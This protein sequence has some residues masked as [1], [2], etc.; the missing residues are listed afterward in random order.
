MINWRALDNVPL[1]LYILAA[2]TLLLCLAFAGAKLYQQKKN[3]LHD[4]NQSG[5]KAAHSTETAVTEKLHAARSAKLSSVLIL[6]DLSAAFDTVNHKTLLSTLRSLG[7]CGTAWEWFA[8]YL[9]GRSYQGCILPPLLFSLYTNDCTSTHP[10]VKLLKFADDT[11][12]IDLIQDGDESAYRQEVEQLAAWC[13]LN[14]LELNTLKTVEMI[15][16]FRMNTPALPPLTIMNSTVPTVE[17]FRF[18]GTT[19]SQDLKWDTDIDSIIKKIVLPSAAEE[20]QPAT[21]AANT[22]LLSHH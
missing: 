10:S 11:T 20:V 6:L 12:V 3:N 1:L 14:N 2:K 21:G 8:S 4:P 18:L 15:M 22:V 7:I 16:D 9:D 19:I 5:F 17:S 13:S